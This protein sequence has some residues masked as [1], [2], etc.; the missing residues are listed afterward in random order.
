MQRVKGAVQNAKKNTVKNVKNVVFACM[1]CASLIII[2]DDI[3]NLLVVFAFVLYNV[4]RMFSASRSTFFEAKN[5]KSF[6]PIKLASHSALD[7]CSCR[8]AKKSKHK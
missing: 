4:I 2:S 3:M 6:F 1:L 8:G 5:N 7:H